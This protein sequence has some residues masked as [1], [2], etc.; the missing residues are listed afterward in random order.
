MTRLTAGALL[1]VFALARPGN[2][3]DPHADYML[4]C[5]GCHGPDGSGARGAVPSFRGEVA[6]FLRVPG[7]REYL[8]RVPGIGPAKVEKYG[9]AI[10]EVIT[11]H[12]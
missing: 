9:E 5:Q 7:G 4:H 12:S 8:L 3:A 2:A 10:L 11:S 1:I 6:K